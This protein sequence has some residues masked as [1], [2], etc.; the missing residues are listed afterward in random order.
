MHAAM[1][2]LLK[3]MFSIQSYPRLYNENQRDKRVSCSYEL[4]AAARQPPSNEDGE[5]ASGRTFII[6]IRYQATTDE[7]TLCVLQYS[8]L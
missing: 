2:D 1:A 6:E 7:K 5:Y 3:A 8:D 4:H